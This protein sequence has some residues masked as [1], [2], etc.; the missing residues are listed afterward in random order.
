MSYLKPEIL[1]IE[2]ILE[3]AKG[4][5][6]EEDSDVVIDEISNEDI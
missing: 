5:S 6:L 2:H 3:D 4:N 1:P